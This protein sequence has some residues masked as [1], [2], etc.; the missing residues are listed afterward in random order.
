MNALSPIQWHERFVQQARWTAQLRTFISRQLDFSKSKSILEVG[1]G[2]G[3]V[4]SNISGSKSALCLG[5]DLRFDFLEF[6]KSIS[7]NQPYVNADGYKLPLRNGAISVTICHFLLLW[8]NDPLTVLSEMR[9]VTEPGGV[10][11]ALAEPDYGG[12]IDHPAEL[13]SLGQL[14]ADSLFAQGADPYIG[15]KIHGLFYQAG[16]DNI[17]SGILGGHWGEP[18]S[19]EA[20]DSEW[21]TLEQDLATTVSSEML[22][23]L[24]EVDA[25]SWQKGERILFIPTFYAW[26]FVPE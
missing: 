8:I 2:T 26:G 23:T 24:R 6:S 3:A 12:R 11:V 1:S 22:H 16:F 10:V 21:T 4:L 25:A 13:V 7:P 14:Q 5:L 17:Q 18:P 19:D 20:W 15:R 9:R